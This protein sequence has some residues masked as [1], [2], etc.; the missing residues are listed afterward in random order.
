MKIGI[1]ARMYGA[2]AA[3]G[4]GQ[5]IKQVTDHLFQIDQENQ[6]FL[7]LTEPIFSQFQEPNE[8]VKKIKVTPHWF[9]YAEQVK[10]PFELA[11]VK[12]DFIHYPNFNTPIFYWKKSICTIHDITP[13]FFPGHKQKSL[14]RRLA[15]KT[16]FWA[17]V[18]KA[19]K[20][21]AVSQATKNDIIKHFKVRP[22]KIK[23]TYLGVDE[24]FKIIE[25]NDIINKAKQKYGIS[26]PFIFF[27]G[28]WR[29]HKNF[30]GLISAFEILKNKHKIEHQLVLGGQGD[31]HYPEIP[32]AINRGYN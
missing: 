3:T 30:E 10:L 27:V 20:I 6:Y 28:A 13:F 11:K 17:T 32:L 9:T 8:Q 31:P 23:I 14:F 16:V 2:K 1:D 26:K 12:L 21:I 25:N 29:N 7:F 4:I 18:K 5:Y 19:K 24:R 22:D 15:Y